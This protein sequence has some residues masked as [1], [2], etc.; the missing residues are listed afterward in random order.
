MAERPI[1]QSNLGSLKRVKL[2]YGGAP[3]FA[4]GRST[5]TI[6]KWPVS[7]RGNFYLRTVLLTANGLD[8]SRR[9]RGFG[10]LQSRSVVFKV[11]VD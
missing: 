4:T 9:S 6:K 5:E 2:E 10:R 8:R 7:N 1:R 3:F 11:N